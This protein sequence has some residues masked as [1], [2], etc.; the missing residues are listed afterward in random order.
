MSADDIVNEAKQNWRKC[1]MNRKSVETG[2]W[3]ESRN[4]KT[5]SYEKLEI[6]VGILYIKIASDSI[7]DVNTFN[8][9]AS[10]I[11]KGD[12]SKNNMKR[13]LT[14]AKEWLTEEIVC[15]KLE[16]WTKVKL[17]G[18]SCHHCWHLQHC[19][20]RFLYFCLK[21][22]HNFTKQQKNLKMDTYLSCFLLYLNIMKR[23]R[24]Q[25][26]MGW[27]DRHLWWKLEDVSCG[28]RRDIWARIDWDS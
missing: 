22:V 6:E 1:W 14:E 16:T 10:N 9:L 4:T 7:W 13:R 17:Q 8:Y 3:I 24:K 20:R 5:K 12:G 27:G 15:V 19:W 21:N 11:T 23:H 25:R 26:H 2:I 18:A 28:L